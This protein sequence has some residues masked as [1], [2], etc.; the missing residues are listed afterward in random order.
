MAGTRTNSEH[1]SLRD[2]LCLNA[3]V[4]SSNRVSKVNGVMM[5]S[6]TWIMLVFILLLSTVAPAFAALSAEDLAWINR[7]TYGVNKQTAMEYERMGRD[8]FLKKQLNPPKD[9]KMDKD[10]IVELNRGYRPQ[11]MMMDDITERRKMYR[12]Q[13]KDEKKRSQFNTI[14][15][16]EGNRAVAIAERRHLMRAIYSPWQLKEQ[17]AWFW[18][19]HFSVFV[20]KA[21]IRWQIADYE[22][23]A[24]RPYALGKFKDI[25]RATMTHPAMLDYLDASKNKK[26]QPNENYAR[27]LMELH[28]L[29]VSGGY[30]Q[31]DVT[32]VARVLTGISAA[33]GPVPDKLK[34]DV[35]I[36][37]FR[38]K[39]LQFSPK[40]HDFKNKKIMGSTIKGKG[41]DEIDALASM[42]AEQPATATHISTKL[43][44][45]FIGDKPDASLIKEMSGQF[46]ASKGDIRQTLEVLFNSEEFL[47][48]LTHKFRTPMEVVVS[49]ARLAYEDNKVQNYVPL[50]SF[51]ASL[52]QGLYQR[53][54]PDGYPMEKSMWDGSSQLFKRFEVVRFLSSGSPRF[55]QYGGKPAKVKAAVPQLDNQFFE[56]NIK[57]HLSP[58][59]QAVLNKTEKNPVLWNAML[60]SS[61]EWMN[62]EFTQ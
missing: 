61:P 41:W 56:Q 44:Q 46:L 12:R 16:R 3:A 34:E 51:L 29:G 33:F 36:G 22:D 32:E 54:T 26:N 17:M 42:L 28:T 19:N 57:P 62:R 21:N 35:G 50:A 13:V 14:L 1:N 47:S 15:R 6:H 30:T 11:E 39:G 37:F 18:L 8:A 24:I 40:D 52:G 49:T 10:T 4:R 53:V 38:K 45:F 31:K 48:S 27:E 60:F 2:Q 59:T 20:K 43:A 55:F 23:N 25:L 58:T 7:V 5:R 9:D